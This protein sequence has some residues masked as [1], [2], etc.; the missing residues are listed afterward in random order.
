MK[1]IEADDA[2]FRGKA[3]SISKL[4]ASIQNGRFT[5]DGR[6]LVVA[7]DL[8]LN[9][10]NLVSLVGC[11][12]IV[13]GD[14]SCKL[15]RLNS[16]RGGPKEVGGNYN[17]TYNML[18]TL[19]GAPRHIKQNFVCSHNKLVTLEGGPIIVGKHYYCNNNMQLTSLHGC[20]QT[21]GGSLLSY[22]NTALTSL[23]GGP[24]VV[25]ERVDLW[26]CSK[27][28]SLKD[29][30]LHLPEVHED[31]V[32][33]EVPLKANIL[34]LLRIKE[35]KQVSVEDEKLETIINKYI[36][37]GDLIACAVELEEAGYKELA[38]L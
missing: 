4:I 35:L 2:S 29:V 20:A 22:D 31:I 13:H 30:H 26:H 32:L 9:N 23:A 18:V 21:I 28:T 6:H 1:L 14:F 8:S 16:L 10:L 27:L 12:S 36:P 3:S 11:P 7:G 37:Y 17:C 34:G 19:D 38:R 24:R 25:K 33:Y 5:L 15:N